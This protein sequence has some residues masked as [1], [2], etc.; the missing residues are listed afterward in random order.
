M[1]KI[2]YTIYKITNQID[3][4]F[5]IG[6]HKTKNLNDSYMG[7]GKYL[8]Y[9]QNKYGIENFNKEILFVC[10]S[11]EDMYAKEAELV[12][13]EFLATANT[14]NLKVGG[15]GGWDYINS[16]VEA[17]IN[18]NRLARQNAE[19][20]GAS[21]KA[22]EYFANVRAEYEK[23]PSFC[24]SCNKQLDFLKRK[25][26]FCGHSCSAKKNNAT[27]VLKRNL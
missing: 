15:F 3:G 13:E 20:V 19:K 23:S 21:Q 10:E 24:T 18:K 17:R 1:V 27:R 14:Y 25:N 22:L 11:A 4:K 12:N 2:F 8:K 5:Y 9:A 7:S 6:T 26:K 16:D